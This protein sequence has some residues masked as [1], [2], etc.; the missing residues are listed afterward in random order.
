MGSG[1]QGIEEL[2]AVEEEFEEEVIDET[3]EDDI[4]F[5]TVEETA[6][7]SKLEAEAAAGTESD[8]SSDG[9][10]GETENKP[11]AKSTQQAQEPVQQQVNIEPPQRFSPEAKAAWANVPPIVKQ[12]YSRAIQN[13]ENGQRKWIAD[14]TELKRQAETIVSAIEPWAKD[15][16]E[17]GIAKHQGVALLAKTHEKM[18]KNPAKTLAELALDNNVTP[19]Q[20]QAYLNGEVKDDAPLQ[21]QQALQNLDNHPRIL[22]L[23]K[24]VEQLQNERDQQIVNAEVEK[25]KALRDQVDA[26]GNRPFGR[27]LDEEFL[28]EAK[29]LVDALRTPPRGADGRFISGPVISLSD[30]Y[31]KAYRVW[32]QDTGQTSQESAASQ[33][34]NQSQPQTQQQRKIAQPVSMRPRSVP[35][36]K[37]PLG[38]NGDMSKYLHESP[39]ETVARLKAQ[40]WQVDI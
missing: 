26:S 20:I 5:E 31:K 15:W 14:Q 7:R 22:S 23:T 27:I 6:E 4:L 28:K 9:A 13:L 2:E 11:A 40:N 16:A 10:E 24:T 18:V 38:S 30:A 33:L 8:Q 12:E 35:A 36:G 29:P 32:L 19:Q 25:L 17:Q 34:T 21:Q 3:D 39:E 1:E 37:T